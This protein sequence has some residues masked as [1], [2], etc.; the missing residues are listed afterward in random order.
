VRI[1]AGEFRGR[2]LEMLRDNSIRPATDR[3]KGSIFNMLQ[4]RL[5]LVDAKV[6]D[7]YAGSGNLAFEA[8]SRGASH[9]VLVDSGRAAVGI[10]NANVELLDCEDRCTVL[11]SDALSFVEHCRE[12]F[13]LIFADPPYKYESIVE[14]PKFIF[15]RKLL[16]PE[17]FLIVEHSKHTTFPESPEYKI[18][19]CKEFGNTRVSFFVYPAKESEL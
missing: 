15:E 6:L 2:R 18:S 13:D 19:V 3:V 17:G 14:I 9:A 7:L 8:L 11:Q 12:T 16:H 1:I 4:N 10:I 5:S